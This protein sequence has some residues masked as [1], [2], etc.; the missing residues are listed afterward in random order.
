MNTK[1]NLSESWKLIRDIQRR[2]FADE[3]R[4]DGKLHEAAGREADP[5]AR[6]VSENEA[7]SFEG[8][9]SAPKATFRSAFVTKLTALLMVAFV[10]VQA[11]LPFEFPAAYNWLAILLVCG[12]IFLRNSGKAAVRE[13][14]DGESAGNLKLEL[15]L[16][17]DKTWEL[18]EREER[19][20]SLAE[21]FG[22]MIMDRQQDGTIT[23]MNGSFCKLLG[24]ET[25]AVNGNPFPIDMEQ[26]EQLIASDGERAVSIMHM[27]V[28]D[29]DRWLA[30][31]DLPIRS[32]TTGE[33]L[34]RTV[35]RDV[36]R[37]KQVE[38]E[39]R[40]ATQKAQS[41]SK[42]KT[43]FL[44]NVSHEMR[45][46]LNGIL[47]MSG[48]LADT[49]LTREQDTY[50]NAVHDSGMALL[51]LIE[52]ILD[53]TL[54]EAGRLEIRSA[55]MNPHKMVEDVCELLASRAHSKG[56]SIGSYIHH[57][58]P[59][60]IHSDVGRVR[61]ILINLI[62]NAIKFTESGGVYVECHAKPGRPDSVEK[63]E[64]LFRVHDTGPGIAESD[65]QL[66]FEEFSQADSKSTRKHGGAGLGLAI[67]RRIIRE[68]GGS[69][70][71]ESDIGKGSCFS[72][73]LPVS[74]AEFS[75]T[76]VPPLSESSRKMMLVTSNEITSTVLSQYLSENGDK[77]EILDSLPELSA[78][79]RHELPDTLLV[80]AS[81]AEVSVSAMVPDMRS[82]PDKLKKIV[83]LRPAERHRLDHLLQSG[84]DG[85]LI[86][87]VRKTSL[88][89]MI[90]D[91]TGEPEDDRKASAAKQWSSNFEPSAKPK[92]VLLAEDNEINALLARSILEK[93]GHA[94]TRANN[95]RET[96]ALLEERME[97]EP[98][99]LV[100]LDLQMPVMDGLE[101]LET[102]RTDLRCKIPVYILTADEQEESRKTAIG[103]GATGFL[104]KPLDP[105]RLLQILNDT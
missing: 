10:A 94:V 81:N 48:L 21:A 87:P 105:G 27:V 49:K 67:S 38:L 79:S 99:D 68:M 25:S 22:D 74:D 77:L 96:L 51:T 6:G 88:L 104:T 8:S 92:S 72:F 11:L 93:A 80:D 83:L 69:M 19:Y 5:K 40:K 57:E 75:S 47:G 100:L 7:S 78:K 53:M 56:I 82:L 15:E 24:V 64:L 62:G 42:A 102:M 103:S 33:T 55:P 60:N 17:Q 73:S 34:I 16:L 2:G 84:F 98:F 44:A 26:I 30:W 18:Q 65:Q 91:V 12:I 3:E 43:Q 4:P 28:A 66:I 63:S 45:T 71:L 9:P 86:K 97:S 59:L 14:L 101:A 61:Q 31:L 36:T 58:V 50:V 32:E 23:Y 70:D 95:G 13:E 35:A 1:R 20:R 39:L 52:D 90:N 41:A 54:V 89:N 37:Q 85:Y 76:P 29:S 46:P